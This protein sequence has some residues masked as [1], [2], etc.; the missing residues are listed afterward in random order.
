MFADDLIKLGKKGPHPYHYPFLALLKRLWPGDYTK[1]IQNMN[2]FIH[3]ESK[4]RQEKAIKSQS[5]CAT[6]KIKPLAGEQEFWK[7]IGI[8]IYAGAI[9]K[10]GH[11]LWQTE[12]EYRTFSSP[13]NLKPVMPEYR[14]KQIRQAFS[15]AFDN[16]KSPEE[17]AYHMIRSLFDGYN[18]NRK[19]NINSSVENVFDES[20]SAFKPR[21]TKEGGLPNISF[22][23]RKPEPI[24]VEYKVSEQWRQ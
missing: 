15:H 24:G 6:K 1:Q 16:G 13:I 10:K 21:T 20:M 9:K 14:F 18:D 8:L 11:Q 19:R 7:F 5:T 12:K 23:Q 4:Q 3:Q 2:R 22:I 17:D